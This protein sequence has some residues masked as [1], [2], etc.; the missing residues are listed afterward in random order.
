MTFRYNTYFYPEKKKGREF[1]LLMMRI[2]WKGNIVHFSLGRQIAMDR[3][4]YDEQ[5]CRN[6][7][8]HGQNMTPALAI[9]NEIG[10]Y[11]AAVGE[12]ME[13]F[14]RRGIC[15]SIFDVKNSVNAIVVGTDRN[16]SQPTLY[17][18]FGKFIETDSITNG[19][20]E[21]TVKKMKTIRKHLHEYS[22]AITANELTKDT[23][24]GFVDWH[25]ANG[26]S[27]NTIQKNLAILKWFIRWLVRNDYYSG[28]AADQFQPKIR[29]YDREVIYL[30]WDELMRVYHLQLSDT[31]EQY[32]R[33]GFCLSCFTG[34]RYSDLANLKKHDIDNDFIKIVTRKTADILY[35][36]INRWSRSILDRYKEWSS[37]DGAAL[38]VFCNQVMNR[39]LKRIGQ[40]AELNG[41]VSMVSYRG[42]QR[43]ET[44]YQ[45]WQLLTTHCGRRTFVVNAMT[46]GVPESVIMSWT[47]H[48]SSAAMKP[49][50]KVVDTLK[51]SMMDR[52]DTLP[53]ET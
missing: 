17:D 9:N 53:D 18:L 8:F 2:S 7:S 10:R 20:T 47:G 46:L 38:P 29:T 34:L 42:S 28:K 24:R 37:P 12:V 27:N 35:I 45:K 13:N 51:R 26:F 36:D 21:G 6:R 14:M 22:P 19:W 44:I 4:D 15:P 48:H 49:Y 39:I 52:F 41:L 11:A 5:R 50:K 40:K 25:L 16:T 23:L 1:G 33:D 32:A 3:W 30:S 43:M 31:N